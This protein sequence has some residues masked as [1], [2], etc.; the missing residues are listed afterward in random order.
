MKSNCSSYNE[1][2]TD[3]SLATTS[4]TKVNIQIITHPIHLMQVC[5]HG[6][7]PEEDIDAE[8]G[9]HDEEVWRGDEAGHQFGV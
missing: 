4:L 7:L 2:A 6:L 9:L 1:T 3:Q 8:L 5:H